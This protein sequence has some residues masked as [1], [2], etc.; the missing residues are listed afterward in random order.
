MDEQLKALLE[1]INAWKSGQEE[2]KKSLEDMQ[3]SQEDTKNE[4][5]QEMQKGLDDTK[6]ELKDR[7]E[8]G[9]EETK[10]G[11]EDLRNSLEKKIDIVEEKINSVEEKITLKVEEKI[12]VLEERIAVVEE[13]IEQIEERIEGVAENFS[14][15][16]QRVED[17]EKKLL[18]CAN[19][20]GSNILPFSSVPVSTSLVPVTASTVS[21]KLSTYDGKTNWERRSRQNTADSSRHRA[22]EFENS[23]YNT[24][25]LRFSQKY[26]KDYARPQMKTRLQKTG[27]SLQEYASEV[28]R[29]ANLAFSD[30]PATVRD[31]IFL[32]Y[33]VDGLKDGEIQGAVRIADVQVLKSALL[34]TLKLETA[35]QA[36]RRDRQSI[37]G[38]RVN[39]DAPC[40]SPWKSD[41]EKLRDEFQAFKAQRQN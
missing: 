25:D 40:E 19:K 21:V 23:L 33:F 38:A 37:R 5:K 18:V 1:G 22:T 20:N 35:T 34:Y 4:L 8:K 7:M 29:I 24:L 26:S 36:S 13:R 27:E 14:L 9:Q 28:E 39:L 10:K 3:K 16:S 6:N 12:A 41:I 11:Q 32:Q 30:H 2:T 17:L 31:L 15:I